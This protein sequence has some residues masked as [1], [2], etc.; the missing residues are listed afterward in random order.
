MKILNWTRDDEAGLEQNC[1]IDGSKN[2][3]S[4]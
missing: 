2:R 3:K 1:I 4:L